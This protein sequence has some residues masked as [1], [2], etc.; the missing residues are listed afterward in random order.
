MFT[1]GLSNVLA[2]LF[3]VGI[4][5]FVHELGHYLVGRFFG[6]RVLVFSLGFG[7][8][9]WGFKRGDTDFRVAMIP[10]GGYVLFDGQDPTLEP[11]EGDFLSKPRWQRILIYLAGPLMNVA[12]AVVLVAGVF[13]NGTEMG[14]RRDLTTE[15]GFVAPDSAAATA[16]LAA[17]DVILSIDGEVMPDWEEVSMTFLTSPDRELEVDFERGGERRRTTLRPEVIPKYELGEAGV[18]PTAMLRVARVVEGGPAE[19]AGFRYADGLLSVDGRPV[20]SGE[21]FSQELAGRQGQSVEVEVDRHGQSKTLI[22]SPELIEGEARIGIHIAQFQF[23]RFPPLEAV[24]QS[25]RYNYDSVRQIV[26]FVG[27]V[28]ERRISAESAVGGPLEIARVSGAAARLGFDKLLMLMALISM[29]LFMINMLPIPILDG[30][31][32]LVL[33]VESTLRRDLSLAMKEWLI[34]V[35][36]AVIVTMMLMV[37]FFDVKKLLP[38]SSESEASPVESP[39]EGQDLST[40][41]AQPV[42]QP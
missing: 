19:R 26:D 21:E 40:E 4:I 32:I 24:K 30:G 28:F 11:Q 2:F 23:Q 7:N 14:N 37:I 38:P 18:W 16:G 15:I 25:V 9:I 41:E 5:I 31:Q 20:T 33:A 3:A 1:I 36:L 34:R 22:V 29:N 12:L 17:G 13:M 39:T 27:K 35:G 8:R 10:L 42:A 6:V